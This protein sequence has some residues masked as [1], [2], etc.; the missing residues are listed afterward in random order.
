MVFSNWGKIPSISAPMNGEKQK[1]TPSEK[2]ER[3][4][5]LISLFKR[6][7]LFPFSSKEREKKQ[8][9]RGV[10]LRNRE[11]GKMAIGI[12]KRGGGRKSELPVIF[13]E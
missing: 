12:G 4:V 5:S 11:K 6:G 9:R 13:T 10:L 7:Q 2:E 3:E 8:E 1:W